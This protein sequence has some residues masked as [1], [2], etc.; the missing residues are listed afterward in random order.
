[1]PHSTTPESAPLVYQTWSC[2]MHDVMC[3]VMMSN[4]SVSEEDPASQRLQVF[5]SACVLKTRR[6]GTTFTKATDHGLI[7]LFS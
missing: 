5:L 1:M 2:S 3:E 6:G 7:C 4:I